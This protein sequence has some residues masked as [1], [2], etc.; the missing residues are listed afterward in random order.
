MYNIIITGATGMIGGML[1]NQCLAHPEVNR[2]TSIVRKPTGKTHEKLAEVIHQNFLDLSAIE[3]ALRN[4]DIC[5][6]CI[7]VYTGQVPKDEFRKITVDYTKAF[8]SALRAANDKT[9]FCFLSGDGADRKEK[10]RLMFARDKGAAENIL[11][12]L[13]FSRCYT[14]RPGYIYPSV[15]RREPNGAYVFFRYAYKY[16]LRFVAPNIGLTSEQLSRVMFHVGLN[17]AEKQEW[18]NRDIRE[19]A[20]LL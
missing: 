5:F 10:S 8:A 19:L 7:G 12:S 20:K 11:F 3:P 15:P 13:N 17:G 14:F 9:A 4:Q 2:V 1:L 16:L 6:Y 18:S